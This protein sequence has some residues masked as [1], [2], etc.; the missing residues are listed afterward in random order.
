MNSLLRASCVALLC[1]AAATGSA[2][3]F[4]RTTVLVDEAETATASL[5]PPKTVEQ[6]VRVASYNIAHARGNEEGKTKNEIARKENL[7][8]IA[9]L[10]KK[11]E[12]DI[13]GLTEISKGDLR[14]KFRNQPKYIAEHAGNL[15]YAYGENVSR[16]LGLLATQGNAVVSRFPILSSKNHVLY[17]T[18]PKHEQRSCLEAVLDLGNGRRLCVLV[19][20]LS[21]LPEEST[22]QIEEIWKLAI[23]SKHPV[24]LMGDFNSRPGSARIKWLASRMK[25]TTANVNTTFLN[26]PDVK[27]DYIFSYGSIRAGKAFVDGF[28]Q[29]YSDHG[30]LINDLWIRY[31]R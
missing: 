31:L 23:D 8:G 17:R 5:V 27:I 3:P 20:H 26:K 30:C 7:D 19:A 22:K 1:L 9:A 18:D 24:V 6:Y 16:L 29:G 11:H 21:L 25:D 2:G 14:A 10:L 15:H 12:I 13:A 28:E 4:D